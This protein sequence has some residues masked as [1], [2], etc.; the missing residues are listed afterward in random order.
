M[1]RHHSHVHTACR[2]IEQYKG[3][4]PFALYARH[5]FGNERKY[6]SS[7]RK[8]ILSLC[9][10]YFRGGFV[11]RQ[12]PLEGQMLAG[13]FLTAQHSLPVL[14]ALRVEYTFH[15]NE[16]LKDKLTLLDRDMSETQ[17]LQRLFPHA[18]LLSSE[19]S[20]EAFTRSLLQ[21]P[22]LYIRLRP[23]HSRFVKEQLESEGIAFRVISDETL[24]LP[25]AT[26]LDRFL[27]KDKYY[28]VQDLNSQRIREFFPPL[29]VA[30]GPRIWDCCAASGGKSILAW[31]HYG[32]ARLTVSDI[33]E[34]ILHNLGRRFRQGGI[35]LENQCCVDLTRSSDA[36]PASIAESPFDL[37]IADVPCSG[38]GTWARSPEQLLFFDPLQVEAYAERQQKILRN[39]VPLLSKGK[40]LLYVTCSVFSRENEGQAAFLQNNCGL[41]LVRSACLKGYD[42]RADT[43]FAALFI[44]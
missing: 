41:G 9:Y 39:L 16:P 38:S 8:A 15:L 35:T 12:L 2:L 29:E 32:H 4:E 18:S 6:G 19:I 34:N 25:P 14:E 43:L 17:F 26:Q 44:A 42:H 21:Q 22:D 27:E 37:V 3:G 13:L 10:G 23:G 1:S 33:R 5:F 30:D 7:D 20:P 28:V 11:F 31:D 36:V 40:Y 24:A